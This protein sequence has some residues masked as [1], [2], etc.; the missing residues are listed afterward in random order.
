MRIKDEYIISEMADEFIAINT[1]DNSKIIKLNNSAGSI[2]KCL[3]EGKSDSEIVAYLLDKYDNLSEEM[4]LNS[5]RKI[6]DD[7]RKQGVDIYE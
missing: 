1:N 2:F 3:N 5:I 4:A 6:I 7:L